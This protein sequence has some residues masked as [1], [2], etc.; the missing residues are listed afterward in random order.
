LSTAHNDTVFVFDDIHW[1]GGMEA[2]WEEIKAH[3][4]VQI[5]IDTFYLG[6]IFFRKEQSKQHFKIRL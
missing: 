4:K 2:A 5:S 6:L 3:P 1:S